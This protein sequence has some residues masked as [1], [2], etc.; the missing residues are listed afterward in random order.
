MCTAEMAPMFTYTSPGLDVALPDFNS[1][2]TCRNFGELY[3]WTKKNMIH[4]GGNW[5]LP[6]G[7][8]AG[9]VE[10]PM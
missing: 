9:A 1:V 5:E 4:G 7:H 3:K 8:A 10:E 2:L 6:H